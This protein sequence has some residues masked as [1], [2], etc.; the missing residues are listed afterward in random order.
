MV[1]LGE[2]YHAKRLFLLSHSLTTVT[3]EKPIQFTQK[4]SI[5]PMEFAW[6]KIALRDELS[7]KL[8]K[9]L[10]SFHFKCMEN[11]RKN[12]TLIYEDV[13]CFESVLESSSG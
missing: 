13:W 12:T 3:N 2:F 9:L 5:R 8:G 1:P 6:W 10:Y 4:M 7:S 11:T